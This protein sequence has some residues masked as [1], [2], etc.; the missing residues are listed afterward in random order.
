[1]HA[2]LPVLSVGS[3]SRKKTGEEEVDARQLQSTD[4]TITVNYTVDDRFLFTLL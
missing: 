2:M 3:L 4:L 1:M